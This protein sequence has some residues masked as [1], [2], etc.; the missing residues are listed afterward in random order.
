ML[1]LIKSIF[2]GLVQYQAVAKP[3]LAYCQLAI[4]KETYMKYDNFHQQGI[5]EG[6]DSWDQPRNL[7]QIGFK[8]LIF[9][10]V[11]PWNEM[12]DLKKQ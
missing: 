4:K 11:W 6:F 7:T 9:Q 1:T 12:D 5:P 8:L 3:A 10:P 2:K